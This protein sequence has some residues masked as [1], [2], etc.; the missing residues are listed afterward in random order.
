[1][2]NSLRLIPLCEIH[3]RLSSIYKK[4]LAYSQN[5]RPL[6]TFWQNLL[7]ASYY[8]L[9]TSIVT[10]IFTQDEQT[11]KLEES[12]YKVQALLLEEVDNINHYRMYPA[13]QLTGFDRRNRNLEHPTNMMRLH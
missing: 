3:T 9:F 8:E 5:Y 6:T 4:S 2:W 13:I 12:D 7:A 1:M 10:S 11:E